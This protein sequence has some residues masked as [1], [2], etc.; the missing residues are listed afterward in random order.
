MLK[1]SFKNGI[2]CIAAALILSGG[3]VQSAYAQENEDVVGAD[4]NVTVE[5]SSEVAGLGDAILIEVVSAGSDSDEQ[6]T[7][8]V[9]EIKPEVVI[10]DENGNE[11]PS[12]AILSSG[13]VSTESARYAYVMMNTVELA[14]ADRNRMECKVTIVCNPVIT[15]MIGAVILYDDTADCEKASWSINTASNSYSLDEIITPTLRHTYSLKMYAELYT[16]SSS[17]KVESIDGIST[18]TY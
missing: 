3:Y 1:T 17:K 10:V 11:L 6:E 18:K 7:K 16:S 12:E 14:L 4:I 13:N 9:I 2:M 5:E 8:D 15:K